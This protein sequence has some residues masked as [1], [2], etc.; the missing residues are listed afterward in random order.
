VSPSS[1]FPSIFN[2]SN[3][4]TLIT[5][6]QDLHLDQYHDIENY[7]CF[8]SADV[9]LH[10]AQLRRITFRSGI[11]SGGLSHPEDIDDARNEDLEYAKSSPLGYSRTQRSFVQ[12][13]DF[14]RQNSATDHYSRNC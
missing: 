3:V 5:G 6:L 2:G 14:T 9:H 12:D 13:H 7:L 10:F 4:D 11:S 8:D 1:S